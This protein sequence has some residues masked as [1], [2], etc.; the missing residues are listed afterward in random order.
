[1]IG[2]QPAH[3][4]DQDVRAPRLE[5]HE[6]DVLQSHV[7]FAAAPS[8]RAREPG[9]HAGGFVQHRFH[10]LPGGS[11]LCLHLAPI[12]FAEI[13]L[14]MSASTKSAAKLGGSR[15]AEICGA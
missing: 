12:R 15:P 8:G 14:S 11:D 9:Q 7:R 2:S 10:G 6:F 1:M 3:L 13:A 5:P 4:R